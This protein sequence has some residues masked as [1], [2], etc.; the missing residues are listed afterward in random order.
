MTGVF[1]G[2]SPVRSTTRLPEP[3]G[4]EVRDEAILIAGG[5]TADSMARL[6]VAG[7]LVLVVCFVCGCSSRTNGPELVAV[8]GTVTLD[9]KPLQTLIDRPPAR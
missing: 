4:Q 8:T 5:P 9:G 1:P 3:Q 2:S 7:S 6:T